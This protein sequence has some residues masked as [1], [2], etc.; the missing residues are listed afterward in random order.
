[1]TIATTDTIPT[2]AQYG[3]VLDRLRRIRSITNQMVQAAQDQN[4]MLVL[5]AGN[6]YRDEVQLLG[7]TQDIKPQNL[8]EREERLAIMRDILNNDACVKRLIY[9]ELD[10]VAKL[11]SSVS[12]QKEAIQ[13]YGA[14][15]MGS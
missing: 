10:R 5:E 7:P 15:A 12:R 14:Q 3:L 6:R 13:A 8:N 11:I 1:M 4:W 9:P 2:S